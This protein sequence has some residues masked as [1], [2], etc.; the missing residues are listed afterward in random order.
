MTCQ[1]PDHPDCKEK[2]ELR[3]IFTDKIRFLCWLCWRDWIEKARNRSE[4]D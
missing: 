1:C 3:T 4:K 2:G